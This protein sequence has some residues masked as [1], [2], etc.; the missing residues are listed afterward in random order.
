M[1]FL[2][3]WK[4]VLLTFLLA[5]G[6]LSREQNQATETQHPVSGSTLTTTDLS[7]ADMEF[8]LSPATERW[9]GVSG[10]KAA[11]ASEWS[12]RVKA[13]T[14]RALRW[15]VKKRDAN[16]AWGNHTHQ[17]L[18]ALQI[19]N[20]SHTDALSVPPPSLETKLSEKEME[21]QILLA[22]GRPHETVPE[23]GQ[24]ARYSL[25]LE[26][27]CKD[28]R[29]FHGHDL[30]ALIQH[31]EPQQ[32]L[33]F[34]LTALAACSSSAHV[35]KRQIR[36]L[37]DIASA[38]ADHNVD[39]IAMVVLALRCIVTDH[40]HRH[41]QHFVR[42]PA[43]GLARQQGSRGGF[44][45]ARTTALAMQA[46]RDMDDAALQWNRS[47]AEEW[48]LGL[49][50]PEGAWGL[51]EGDGPGSA[52]GLTADVALGLAWRGLAAVRDLQCD[53]KRVG[54]GGDHKDERVEYGSE[55]PKIA[56]PIGL[57]WTTEQ[58]SESPNVSITYT[59]WHGQ[60]NITY[61]HSITLV[62]PRNTSFYSA[63][64][65]AADMDAAFEFEASDWPNGHYVHTLGGKKEDPKGYLY[66]L[67]YRLPEA[68]DV[69]L[70]PGNQHV[71]P[72]G[73]DG[74]TVEDGEHYLF[75]YKKL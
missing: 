7:E 55:G 59:L 70:P 15:L 60:D 5:S 18:L 51:G 26:S 57:T 33:E 52:W 36:R 32:D 29:K 73:V 62:C 54:N 45:S 46:L 56:A 72:V 39:T 65:M 44:G 63:M 8:P 2:L 34:A 40:R 22:L 49:Q 74:L 27:L 1:M 53:S 28:P 61:S 50:T 21:I 13:A 68:P 71:A 6:V 64:L 66:W 10:G 11:G 12:A 30:V 47:A 43:R 38:A 48:L 16:G 42:R 69:Q 31:H 75:W 24:L 17:V 19:A 41:L 14:H 20:D 25:A 58:E 67:L 3:T 9:G 37:L 4:T 23:P 35:R